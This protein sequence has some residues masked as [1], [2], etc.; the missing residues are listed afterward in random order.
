MFNSS[1]LKKFFFRSFVFILK[2][3]F[4]LCVYSEK[5]SSSIAQAYLQLD[6]F[7]S[8]KITCRPLLSNLVA[9]PFANITRVTE[10]FRSSWSLC[11][12]CISDTNE[13]AGC[14]LGSVPFCKVTRNLEVEYP[15]IQGNGKFRTC[16]LLRTSWSDESGAGA[17]VC[18]VLHKSSWQ[19]VF[20][21]QKPFCTEVCR[22]DS[23]GAQVLSVTLVHDPFTL[24]CQPLFLLDPHSVFLSMAAMP[25]R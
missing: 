2:K 16:F 12:A 25:L 17:G 6:A 4:F 9:F 22:A 1:I 20:R 3:F 24:G 23:G 8:T 7:L 5:R 13:A 14:Q 10:S 18:S 21:D 19:L 15:A 11:Y